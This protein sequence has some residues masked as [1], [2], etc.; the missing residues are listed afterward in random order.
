MVRD[1]ALLQEGAELV[2]GDF[3]R[4][5][6]GQHHQ[7]RRA[8]EQD[9]GNDEWLVPR[10]IHVE[11]LRRPGLAWPALFVPTILC[12][13]RW[14][15]FGQR[16]GTCSFL[17][18][19]RVQYLSGV[20]REPPLERNFRS[21]NIEIT[22]FDN[23]SIPL[24]I[25]CALKSIRCIKPEVKPLLNCANIPSQKEKKCLNAYVFWKLYPI[26]N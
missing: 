9:G 21:L 18:G 2:E 16:V 22:N 11:R 7:Q 1:L 12:A 5:V 13:S 26:A 14:L 3:S 25:F 19:T 20:E 8:A 17:V 6:F 23:G 15:I 24:G 10:V 4:P